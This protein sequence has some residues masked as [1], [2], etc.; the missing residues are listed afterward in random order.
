MY[1]VIIPNG[2]DP[3]KLTELEFINSWNNKRLFNIGSVEYV[4]SSV[5]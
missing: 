2:K 5:K 3:G 4:F 1:D